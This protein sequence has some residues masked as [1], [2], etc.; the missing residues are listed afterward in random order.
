MIISHLFLALAALVIGTMNLLS[1]K[2]TNKHKLIGWFWIAFMSYVSIFSFWI[3][4]IN[5]G[6]YS[7]I[8]LL[9]IWTLFSLII[10]I[11]A[12]KFGYI[13]THKNFMIG[14]YIGLL[15]A[16]IFTL[17]PGRFIANYL[18]F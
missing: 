5:E 4:E 12:I 3:K 8:H 17:L 18:G 13:K 10:S 1:K 11:I 9:S 15:I 6:Q 2:G 16:G 14:T 7:W